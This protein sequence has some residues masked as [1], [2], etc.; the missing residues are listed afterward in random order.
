MCDDG[1]MTVGE[2]ADFLRVSRSSVY[3]L[4][5]QGKLAFAKFGKSRRIPKKA[6][7]ELAEKSLVG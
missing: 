2:A 4:M 7:L 3:G 6:L 1:L 5:E